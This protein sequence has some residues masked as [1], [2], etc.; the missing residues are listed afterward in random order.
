MV[1]LQSLGD[2]VIEQLCFSSRDLTSEQIALKVVKSAVARGAN[3]T[4][5]WRA[6][7]LEASKQSWKSDVIVE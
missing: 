5:K 4:L 7:Y 6:H 3:E 1:G 2:S